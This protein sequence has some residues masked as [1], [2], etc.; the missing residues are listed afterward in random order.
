MISKQ[1]FS[2]SQTVIRETWLT[3]KPHSASAFIAAFST[4]LL[5]A[6][7]VAYWI[8]PENISRAMSASRRLVFDDGQIWRLWSTIFAHADAG[9]LLSNSFLFF[10]LGFFLYGYFGFR[11][12]PLAALFWGGLTNWVV[13]K[14][15]PPD[16]HLIG[17][18]GV[19]YWMGG[20]WLIL[21]FLLSLQK[22]MTQRL[23]RTLGV[24][25]LL[26]LPAEAFEPRTSYRTHFVGF[27]LGLLAGI[28]H[29][30]LHRKLFRSAEVHEVIEEEPEDHDDPLASDLPSSESESD[31]D[32]PSNPTFH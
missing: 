28:L 8:A 21:Y 19:V 1:K 29:Y 14:T 22:S 30:I 32:K 2:V 11:L 12:F 7:S 26:F 10:I 5:T 4:F 27:L 20:A 9:H 15:Y 23:L 17:A 24:A 6:G 13:L 25:F 3:K 18:S 31:D 16:V